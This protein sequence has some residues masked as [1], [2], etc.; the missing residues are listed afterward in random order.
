MGTSNVSKS[1]LIKWGISILLAVVCFL[2][3]E[4][5]I[6]TVAVRNFLAITVL[7]L[8]LCAFEI[9]PDLFIGILLPSAYIWFNIAP[10]SVVTSPW[11]G[12]TMVMIV[13][14]FVLATSLE[15]CGLLKRLA[16]FLM[17]RVKSNYMAL[18]FV[19]MF[20]GILINIL[21]SGRAYLILPPLC[22]GLCVSLNCVGRNMGVGIATACLVGSCTSHAFTFQPTV[23]GI[24]MNA[25]QNYVTANAVTPLNIMLYCWPLVIACC[26]IVFIVG[27]WYKP[28]QEVASFDY[29][30]EQL[31]AMGPITRRE[32]VNAVVLGIL[33]VYIFTIGVTGLNLNLGFAIIP[34][35]LFLPFVDGA[36]KDV[37]K[38]INWSM[39]FMFTAF[40]AIGNV[41]SHL[42][43][44]TVLS[45]VCI[46]I[47]NQFG[48]NVIT[49][50]ALV[51]AVVFALNFLM[52]PTAI[53]A[54]ISEP[55][56]IVA[57][58][59]GYGVVPFLLA[60]NACS[61]AILFPYEYIPYL[62]VFSF[63]MMS[64]KDFI[65]TNVVRSIIFF[66]FFLAVLI[67]YWMLI[68]IL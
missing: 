21:T 63:G 44:G 8:A 66:G 10:A 59:L 47:V 38:K 32:R 15:A 25:S 1:D 14:A 51:F 45:T 65:K 35:I 24:I 29:F 26:A 22:Y 61:E 18:L 60:A 46:N 54:L 41:A 48:N 2:I 55:M 40:M 5:E 28:D 52:T 27:K 43:L 42:G 19:I 20:V 34:F 58:T 64:M 37:F 30:S 67:P 31:K 50:F 68:G 13:G 39:F 23:W 57:T 56:C 3:P 17:C 33:L 12:T 9:V 53:F 62:L 36:D 49:V 16:F 11:V 4:S 6:Y 7:F